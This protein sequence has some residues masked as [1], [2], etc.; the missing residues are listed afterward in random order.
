MNS[1][2]KLMIASVIVLTLGLSAQAGVFAVDGTQTAIVKN[3]AYYIT[4]QFIK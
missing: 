4:N 1:I 3:D 2:L